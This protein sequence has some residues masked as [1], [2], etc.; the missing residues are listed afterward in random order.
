MTDDSEREFTEA[1]RNAY[2]P[3]TCPSCG[4]RAMIYAFAETTS[5]ADGS[6]RKFMR[7]RGR[8]TN[9]ACPLNNNP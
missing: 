7:G 1:E 4:Q 6:N 8:C 9:P 5:L 3:Q 2:P